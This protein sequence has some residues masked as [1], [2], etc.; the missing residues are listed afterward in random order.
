MDCLTETFIGIFSRFQAI[1]LLRKYHK[2]S[3]IERCNL[4]KNHK[5][6]QDNND[7]YRF[8]DN[9]NENLPFLTTSRSE[10]DLIESCQIEPNNK[11]ELNVNEKIAAYKAIIWEKIQDIQPNIVDFMK[12]EKLDGT[13]LF[14]NITRIN[15]NGVVQLADKTQ[16]LPPWVLSAMKCLANWPKASGSGNCLPK[17]PGFEYDVFKLIR[18]YFSNLEEPIIPF[19]LY[20]LILSTFD[21]Y[22]QENASKFTK[23]QNRKMASFLKSTSTIFQKEQVP[24]NEINLPSNCVYET[25]FSGKE[26]VTKIVPIDELSTTFPNLADYFKPMIGKRQPF[27][28]MNS[29]TMSTSSTFKAISTMPR[30]SSKLRQLAQVNSSTPQNAPNCQMMSDILCLDSPPE[31]SEYMLS[32]DMWS[33]QRQFYSLRRNESRRSKASPLGTPSKNYKLLQL[34]LL[35]LPSPNRRHLQFLLRLFYKIIRNKELCLLTKDSQALKEQVN[36]VYTFE[37]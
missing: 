29:S 32:K 15:A 5:D 10:A 8:S 13:S 6:L 2:S 36:F 12:L 19:E 18:D 37:A 31:S 3:I 21:N 11:V 14:N 28:P 22:I 33:Q 30:N 26:P 20:K 16:D 4:N 23:H 17:Y 9:A 1:N 35:T 24:R 34:V 7:L 27:S 25:A